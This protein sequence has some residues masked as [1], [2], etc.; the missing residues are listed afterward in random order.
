M[1]KQTVSK[2][3]GETYLYL[4]NFFLWIGQ[5]LTDDNLII[6]C[7]RYGNTP[8]GSNSELFCL[9]LHLYC[10]N[11]PPS[12]AS[13]LSSV[14]P[15]SSFSLSDILEQIEGPIHILRHW[16]LS[17]TSPSSNVSVTKQGMA[18]LAMESDNH[19]PVKS[20]PIHILFCSPG[21]NSLFA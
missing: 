10:I 11:L 6:S 14:L 12:P 8:L 4:V 9:I 15:V 18:N 21:L 13:H 2:L 1:F 20:L 7:S 3:F 17:A 5:I 19:Q 16:A